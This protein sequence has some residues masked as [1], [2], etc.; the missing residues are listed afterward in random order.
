MARTSSIPKANERTT[1]LAADPTTLNAVR[2]AVGV[3]AAVLVV[4]FVLTAW[5]ALGDVTESRY[6]TI[7]LHMQRT[8]GLVT[9]WVWF[10]GTLLPFWGKP[11][12]YFW[13]TA[14]SFGL[15]GVS[16]WTSRLPGL[17]AGAA[18]LAM[19]FAFARRTWGL[20][21]AA[22]A[23]TVL[24]SSLLF[25]VLTGVSTTDMALAG[26]MTASMAAFARTVAAEGPRAR[27]WWGVAL[28]A[29]LAAGSLVK[30][31]IAVVIPGASI[32]LWLA[33]ARRWRLLARVPWLTVAGVFVVATVPWYLLAERATPGFLRYFLINEHVLRYIKPAYGDLYGSGNV[34]PRG[35]IWAFLLAGGLPWTGLAVAALVRSFRAAR[36]DPAGGADPWLSYAVLWGVTPALFFTLARQAL[37]S[38]PLPGLPGLALATGAAL[39]GWMDS[40][41][42]RSLARSLAGHL[43]GIA[44]LLGGIAW[45]GMR[46]HA[47]AWVVAVTAVSAVVVLG[48]GRR[49]WVRNDSVALTGALGL[50]AVLLVVA[51]VGLYRPAI[52][53][54]YSTK[55]IISRLHADAATA[56]RTP[57]FPF[58][59]PYSAS[60]YAEVAGG[61][62]VE[63]HSS[64]GP[65]YL[66]ERLRSGRDDVFV[67]NV[68]DWTV[69]GAALRD[70]LRVVLRT[71][72]WVACL[73][74]S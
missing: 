15:L 4:R 17:L 63:Q 67:F 43:L 47:P 8:G 73:P 41:S 66:D 28:A 64:K 69:L 60:F 71:E 24:A 38:Y 33:L 6:A 68:R 45:F 23:T 40:E 30:G 51:A 36:R 39:V 52:E 42:R 13:L 10:D 18:T 22:V 27:R 31:P 20:R 1:P 44:V 2:W 46:Q 19:V 72:N 34:S 50:A 21:V 35:T 48:M 70:R 29:S 3:V 32:F 7:A 57:V 49:F 59:T 14:A 58:R 12:L 5:L 25:F 11:P 62:A 53:D 74:A 37:P 26:A 61:P 54:E 56:G 55:T 9:P 65:P 16:E